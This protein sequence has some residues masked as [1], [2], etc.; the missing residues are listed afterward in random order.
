MGHLRIDVHVASVVAL[1]LRV[2]H[3]V[4]VVVLVASNVALILRV[5]HKIHER[6]AEASAAGTRLVPAAQ[7]QVV[8]AIGNGSRWLPRQAWRCWWTSARESSAALPASVE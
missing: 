3:V 4:H 8:A 6:F 1:L 2:A 5:R 7:A